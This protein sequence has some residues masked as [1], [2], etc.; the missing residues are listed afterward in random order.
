MQIFLSMENEKG[1]NKESKKS[2]EIDDLG[3]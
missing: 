1:V 2:F 3:K